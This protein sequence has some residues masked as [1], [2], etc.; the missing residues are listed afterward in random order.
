V[1]FFYADDLNQSTVETSVRTQIQTCTSNQ[2]Y[3]DNAVWIQCRSIAYQP[4]SNECGPRALLSLT[5]IGIHPTPSQDVLLP[6]MSPNLAQILRIWI[7]VSLLTGS[8]TT[9]NIPNW[10]SG[11]RLPTNISIPTYL[12]HWSNL[13]QPPPL[14]TPD[15]RVNTTKRKTTKPY[16]QPHKRNPLGPYQET[17]NNNPPPLQ[18][19]LASSELK[20]SISS[21][22]RHV[23]KK[24]TF[25]PIQ[26]TL[27]DLCN[28]TTPPQP[29]D[30]QETWGH[31]PD[32]ITNND[33]LCIVFSNP[34][35]L[36]LSSDI[37]ETEYSLGRTQALGVGILCLAE[38]NVNWSHPRVLLKF[39][40]SLQKIWKHSA[41]SKSYTADDF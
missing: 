35:G 14:N 36:K 9:P 38:T 12:F 32:P 30:Y 7:T 15:Q 34:K 39:H 13:S 31:F 6:F 41:N 22:N 4:H 33:T 16:K 37:L 1:H 24:V 26:R 3:P 10:T 17:V 28:I 5:L 18:S 27:Y 20:P 25:K 21:T 23:T 40:G 8:V 11:M 2:F 29:D 19:Q